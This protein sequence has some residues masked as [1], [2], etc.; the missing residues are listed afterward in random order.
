MRSLT[1]TALA[2]LILLVSFS[3]RALEGTWAVSGAI[4]ARLLSAVEATGDSVELPL[5]V[6]LRLAKGW[7]TYWRSPGDAGLPPVFDWSGSENLRGAV[8]SFPVPKRFTLQGFETLGHEGTVVFPVAVSLE[9]PGEAA[10][11]RLRADLSLCS[12]ICVPERVSLRLEI[13][14]GP[15]R[16]GAAAETIA[17][18]RAALP[19][20]G[21]ASDLSSRDAV[22]DGDVLSVVV[23]STRP[24][25]AP[26]LLVESVPPVSFAAPSFATADDGR[27][28][29]V[30][31]KPAEGNAPPPPGSPLTL[32]LIDGTRAAEFHV[33]PTRAGVGD[34][35]GALIA[36]LL[37]GLILNLMP[38]VLPVLSLKLLSVMEARGRE[39]RVARTGF[40][41]SAA[42]IMSVFVVLALI[43]I[44][45]RV[46]G[47]AVGW[48]V[49]F[50][51]P[52][53][54]TAMI[55]VTLGFALNLFGRF[56]IPVPRFLADRMGGRVG[57]FAGGAFAAV[58]STPCSAPFVGTAA[59]FALAGG[60]LDSLAVFLALGLGL[61]APWLLAAAWPGV[62]RFLPRPGV[63]M[64]HLRRVL[65]LL[66]IGT[67]LWLVRVLVGLDG[68]ATAFSV[69]AAV[70][71]TVA[72]LWSRIPRRGPVA[73]VGI[74]SALAIAAFSQPS[75]PPVGSA[76]PWDEARANELV[77]GGGVVLIEA[78]ADWCLTCVVNE[79]VVLARDPTASLLRDRGVSVMRAD[80]TRGD[81]A[82]FDLLTRHG[83][84]G[85]PFT[86]VMGPSAP[87]G[88]PLSEL[89]THEEV[90]AAV[91]RAGGKG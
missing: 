18:A 44:G 84:R 75:P 85:V 38:C 47:A 14:S 6:E 26:D 20:D 49:Q 35:S 56:E 41:A 37:G 30:R 83:R 19:D 72:A 33:R 13:P 80:W 52:V 31:V 63:W 4:Q 55:L 68:A 16:P 77:A 7:K 61:A 9:R 69:A 29:T 59:A 25:S 48:G 70:A 22:W 60:P 15:A 45:A 12:D 82:V 71:V 32:T 66:L 65:G 23:A 87:G 3:S 21:S 91:E 79:R 27:T 57:D 43:L 51:S 62:T 34:L 36:G 11:V 58:M 88:I 5:A 28:A 64:L 17:V 67:A 2:V 1:S 10:V 89:L 76:A 53:F 42:G 86:L 50:Q 74:A 40:L 46:A 78:G 90:A 8:V 81:P 39:R 24:F 54:V 73:V